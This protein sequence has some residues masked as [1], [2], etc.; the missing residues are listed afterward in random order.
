M[1]LHG[2]GP[3]RQRP[4]VFGAVEEREVVKEHKEEGSDLVRVRSQEDALGTSVLNRLKQASMAGIKAREEE[5]TEVI[6]RLCYV[7]LIKCL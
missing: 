7:F 4:G 1:R 3:E 5:I 2:E 6:T